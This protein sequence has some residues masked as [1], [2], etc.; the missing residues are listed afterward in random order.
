MA[1]RICIF[2]DGS[3]AS[4]ALGR[5][6]DFSNVFRMNLALNYEGE[7]GT[8]Q[9]ALYF[10]GVGTRGDRFSAASG[11][12]LVQI[13]SEAYVNLSSNYQAGD[14][15]YI[16]GWSRGA[17][18]ARSIAGLI[19]K[20]GLLMPDFLQYLG[21]VWSLYQY[22]QT[23][24]RS[25]LTISANVRHKARDDSQAIEG[26]LWG[27]DGAPRI[28]VLGLFDTV[29]G[30][31]WDKFQLV[32]DLTYVE[33]PLEPVVDVGIHLLSIDDRRHP[34]FEPLL[35]SGVSHNGQTLEQIWMPGV[36][37]DVGGNSGCGYLADLALQAM[38]DRVRVHC[39]ELTFSDWTLAQNA[40]AFAKQV[41]I[42]ISN[43]CG[44]IK[45]LLRK[46]PRQVGTRDPLSETLHPAAVRMLGH[47]VQIRG[48][49]ATYAGKNFNPE[50]RQIE[51]DSAWQ[52]PGVW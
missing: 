6:Q 5:K 31:Y 49:P 22:R 14:S 32:D 16:F 34:S 42:A 30:R 15:I 52:I 20:V 28:R 1:K 19:D 46:S 11:K 10:T 24:A 40:T 50:M 13:I 51:V 9:Q 45:R 2:L 18:A 29:P 44:G 25:P 12:G 4:A 47:Q 17:A 41:G 35:W 36:H 23:S 3:A 27:G 21:E 7:D 26:K 8:A 43:E 38:I 33:Q 39:P 37:G 48:R